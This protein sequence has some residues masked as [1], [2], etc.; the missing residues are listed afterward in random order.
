MDG[1]LSHASP[2]PSPSVSCWLGLN[3]VGQLSCKSGIPS[4]SKSEPTAR[5]VLKLAASKT[6]EIPSR[7]SKI[8]DLKS[9]KARAELFCCFFIDL[10]LGS[11]PY[12]RKKGGGFQKKWKNF[13]IGARP[14]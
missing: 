1:Q 11:L 12:K 13:P 10:F 14:I 2:I 5:A 6:A 3:T 9:A 7:A 4:P 8:S